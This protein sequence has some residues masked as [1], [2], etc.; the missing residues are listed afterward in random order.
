MQFYHG[1]Y[2]IMNIIQ[3][4]HVHFINYIN[5][6]YPHLKNIAM[7]RNYDNYEWLRVQVPA[8]YLELHEIKLKY[9]HLFGINTKPWQL[10]IHVWICCDHKYYMNLFMLL[11]HNVIV[12]I[13]LYNNDFKVII[14]LSKF[15]DTDVM[16]I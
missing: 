2:H 1:L 8:C 14:S 7:L 11:H 4:V 9:Q 13:I 6:H 3:I 12:T 15:S 5:I 16:K 10:P